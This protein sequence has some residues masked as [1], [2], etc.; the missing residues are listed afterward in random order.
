MS[1]L[2]TP[3]QRM[4]FVSI[5][6]GAIFGVLVAR[7]AIL[8]SSGPAEA[9]VAATSS[10]PQATVRANIVDR[11]GE[12]LVRSGQGVSLA[13][14]PNL[15]WDAEG[16]AESLTT[17]FPGLKKDVIAR[18]L[19]NTAQQFVWI[20]R[21][22][23]EEQVDTVL[24]LELE[25]LIFREEDIRIYPHGRLAGHTLGYVG[26]DGAGLAGIEYK[27]NE[28]LTTDSEPLKLTL[29]VDVQYAVETELASA[30]DQ[31]GL[32]G[33]SGIV[34]DAETGA[35]R[36]IASWPSLDPSNPAP[37]TDPASTDRVVGSVYDLGSVFKPL[38]I[39]AALETG[40]A[41][42]SDR[43][44]ISAPLVIQKTEITDTHAIPGPVTL[45]DVITESSNKGTVQVAWAL[46]KPAQI[47]LFRRAGFFEKSP[48][49][50]SVSQAPLVP[51]QWDELAYATTS[52]GHGISIT[53][54]VFAT[55]FSSFANK[56]L[57][58]PPTLIES[59]IGNGAAER[60]FDADTVRRVNR[61]LRDTVLVGTGTRA[62]VPGYRVAGKTGTA[63]K[64]IDGVY[65]EDR[66]INS[67][68]AFFPA[69]RPE[70]VVLVVLDEPQD[71][72]AGG[73]T[74]AWNAAPTAARIIERIAP[75]LGVMPVFAD[76]PQLSPG[77]TAALSDRSAMQ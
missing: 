10:E 51:P 9:P 45:S 14:N 44:D 65:D 61:M 52:Y 41:D 27:F 75:H 74:A 18:R 21:G 38:I 64:P 15:V 30:A 39:A 20:K 32:I 70:Y 2:A 60:V 77:E 35:V 22:L 29:D 17:V 67:F 33:A 73:V 49:E 42:E 63:E 1:F 69:D 8:A 16:A 26:R 62:A 31:Y 57:R 11:D 12:V 50:L 34:L 28:R 25:G 13:A 23:T 24:A 43:Y 19:A 56:G 48:V 6:L 40:A 37:S 59:E 53:P 72:T 46:G 54:M 55:A 47:D 7:G 3:Q 58:V 71:G 68:A 66:N 4:L 76:A 5:G 36:A